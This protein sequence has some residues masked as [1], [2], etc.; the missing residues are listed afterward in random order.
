[1]VMVGGVAGDDVDD[2]MYTSRLGLN[3]HMQL[4]SSGSLEGLEGSFSRGTR[5]VTIQY[6]VT[7]F[8]PNPQTPRAMEV[9]AR[10][11]YYQPLAAEV[12]AAAAFALS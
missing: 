1:M 8:N 3:C 9:V 12:D 2:A 6:A 7:P 4:H 11:A 5:T 10:F